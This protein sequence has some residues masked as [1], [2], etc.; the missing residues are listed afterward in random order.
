MNNELIIL[1]LFL[2]IVVVIQ[3]NKNKIEKFNMFDHTLYYPDVDCLL[4]KNNSCILRPN[5]VSFFDFN[6]LDCNK[7]FKSDKY[8]ELI[9]S[10]C[11]DCVSDSCNRHKVVENFNG[12]GYYDKKNKIIYK[13]DSPGISKK[14]RG[15]CPHFYIKEKDNCRKI[16]Y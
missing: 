10:T 2:V 12:R 4:T 15:H 7:K 16:V 8:Y 6:N 9:N 11:V 3:T 5:N 13:T 14:I 1:F